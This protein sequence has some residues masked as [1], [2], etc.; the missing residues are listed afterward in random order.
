MSRSVFDAKVEVFSLSS[1]ERWV[2]WQKITNIQDLENKSWPN[3]WKL[4]DDPSLLRSQPFLSE[5][6]SFLTGGVTGLRVLQKISAWIFFSC[7][8]K[9]N[10]VSRCLVRRV[11]A[12]RSGSGSPGKGKM[13]NSDCCP[14]WCGEGCY[15]SMG[16]RQKNTV[17]TF[18]D[19]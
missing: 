10:P 1:W 7:S 14:K 12:T 15:R 16:R 3:Q 9:W 13:V 2:F 18:T 19:H 4:G 11:L 5:H 17:K 6:L 8:R